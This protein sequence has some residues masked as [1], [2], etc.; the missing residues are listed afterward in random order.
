MKRKDW[1]LVKRGSQ[2]ASAI[3]LFVFLAVMFFSQSSWA[4]GIYYYPMRDGSI[5]DGTYLGK[6]QNFRSVRTNDG[7]GSAAVLS[8]PA[9]AGNSPVQLAGFSVTAAGGKV[10]SV[11]LK[12]VCRA[13]G[14]A[15]SARLRGALRIGGEL[16]TSP[17]EF[18][19]QPAYSEWSYL[20]NENPLT[21]GS[22]QWSELKDLEAGVELTGGEAACTK[23]S[24]SIDYTPVEAAFSSPN[25]PPAKGGG[26]CPVSTNC[27]TMPRGEITNRTPEEFSAYLNILRVFRDEY[28]NPNP[29]G[30]QM[31]ALYYRFS[32]L[33]KSGWLKKVTE[34]EIFLMTSQPLFFMS[35]SYATIYLEHPRLGMGLSLSGLGLILGFLFVGMVLV[36]SKLKGQR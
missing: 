7:D 22:W 3:F 12:L 36:R 23:I 33:S 10:N 8:A 20:W 1:R 30:R 19:L 9:P 24:L 31:V 18:S 15:A 4:R 14:D 11:R 29:V 21:R 2:S 17:E 27:A 16:F 28:L 26:G 13:G 34:S 25:S 35:V 6:E 5:Q 32:D